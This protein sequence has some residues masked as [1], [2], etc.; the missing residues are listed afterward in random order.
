MQKLKN[1]FFLIIGLAIIIWSFYMV[2]QQPVSTWQVDTPVLR[3]GDKSIAVE[4]A[5][6]DTK[7]VQGLSGR[8]SL[9]NDTGLL[10]IFEKAEDQGFWMKDMLF[11]IDIVWIDENWTVIGIEKGVSPNSYPRVYSSKVPVKYVLE[12]NSD[13]SSTLGIDIGSKLFLDP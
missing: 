6:T 9:Q 8:A 11:D 2:L 3:V 10:F 1:T 4:I 5:D 12:L 7:R 13:N